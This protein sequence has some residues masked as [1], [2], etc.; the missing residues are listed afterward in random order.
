MWARDMGKRK[1]KRFVWDIETWGLDCR[2][3]A[4]AC[5][6]NIDT[7]EEMFFDNTSDLRGYFENEAPCVVYAH[8]SHGFDT[9]SIIGKEEAYNASKIAMGTNI[10]ELTIN[11]VRYRDTKHLFPMRLA[12]LGEALERSDTRRYRVL[13]SRL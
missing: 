3:F 10:Y 2:N 9:F 13:L 7:D 11:K 4:F 12:Q 6:I 8:N 1:M 5:V